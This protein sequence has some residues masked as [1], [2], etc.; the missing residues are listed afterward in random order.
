[1][2]DEREVR[3]MLQRRSDTVATPPVGTA[4]VVRRARRRVILNG[5]L[6]TVAAVAITVATFAGVD[7]IRSA[8]IPADDPTP[9]G[10]FTPVAGRILYENE[11][12]VGDLGYDLG[13]WA[14]D[15]NGPTDSTV[16]PSVAD[17]V[18]STLVGLDLG[19]AT[20]L[21]WSS[22]GTELLFSR[23]DATSAES[24]FP[25]ENLYV[26]HADGSETLLNRDP[27]MFGGATI[28]PD[29]TRVAF[30]AW[31]DDLGLW[32]VDVDKGRPVRLPTPRAEGIVADP[33]FSPDGTQIA[34]VDSGNH[35]N[36][37]WVMD[38]DGSNAHEILA[39]E[40][41]LAEGVGSLQWSPGG[42]RI[43][44]QG[45]APDP[46]G[47]NMIYT[48][49]PDGSDFRQIIT[50]GM[51]PYWS[52]DGSQIAYTIECDLSDTTCGGLAIADADGANVRE[53]GFA[54]SGPW[55]PGVS[56]SIDETTP[57]PATASPA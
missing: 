22:D 56:V 13:I 10:I 41:S 11:A 2:I 52:P 8:P 5:A 34:Y 55:H 40:P 46:D 4:T 44:M 35:E 47:T 7:A 43:A 16:G 19:E 1:M 25:M 54:A 20:P 6:A 27:M 28:S 38:A 42:D 53:F 9:T 17:D 30:A 36:H 51:S 29:G 21:G 24:L 14:V 18:S 50:G 15:P 26:L 39:N 45:R 37:V 57:T 31:G 3:E 49:A 33:A 48:S 12:E 23:P 32:V